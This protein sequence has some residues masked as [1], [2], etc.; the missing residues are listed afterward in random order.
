MHEAD[1]PTELLGYSRDPKWRDMSD[2]LVHFTDTA[3]ALGSILTQGLVRGSGPFGWDV[4]V[5]E[6]S[7][8]HRSACFSEVPI[9]M[10]PR[11]IKAHGRY[12]VAFRRDLVL[13][14]GGARVWYLDKA[15]PQAQALHGLVQTLKSNGDFGSPL[16]GLT[17]FVSPLLPKRYA[18]EWE[19]EWRVPGGLAFE[20]SEIAFVITPEGDRQ[21]FEMSPAIEGAV[22]S[23]DGDS[24]W[25]GLP[26][27]LGTKL[28]EMAA[29]FLT[30]FQD[31]VHSLPTDGG[32]YVWLVDEW[33]TSTAMAE[34]FGDLE[35]SVHENLFY[36]LEDISS[37]WVSTEALEAM[38]DH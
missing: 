18:Y 23:S 16:W 37:S 7:E 33:D 9:D 24:W 4:K 26:S 17:P 19:R 32:Q 21:K 5:P 14:A 8:G 34:V 28:D 11:L 10:F 35:P 30:S 2:Y 3:E 12:G 13:A 38:W 27:L 25:Y 29:E 20:M 1:I 22:V 31:P 6:V 36:Y 15:G